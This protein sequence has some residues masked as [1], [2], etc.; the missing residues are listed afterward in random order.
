MIVHTYSYSRNPKIW[1]DPLKFDPL[2]FIEKGVNTYDA[3]KYPQ[4][5]LNPR[6]CLGKGFAM[7]EAKYKYI[8]S[9]RHLDLNDKS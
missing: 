6:L 5:N 8:I 2:R 1:K 4:F 9:L 3:Y 7:S